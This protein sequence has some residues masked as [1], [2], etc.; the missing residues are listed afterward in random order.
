MK[1]PPKKIGY[2]VQLIWKDGTTTLAACGGGSTPFIHEDRKWAVSYRKT[3]L[4]WGFNPRS[5][6][7]V[8]VHYTD[9]VI[10][11]K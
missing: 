11:T 1:T 2:A 6:K 4:S 5:V 9:P 8:T 7:V 10:V 3:F